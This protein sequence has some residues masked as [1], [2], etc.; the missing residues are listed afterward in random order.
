MIGPAGFMAGPKGVPTQREELLATAL[1][2]REQAKRLRTSAEY[3]DS[4]QARSRDENDARDCI[5]RAEQMEKEAAEP[6]G[7]DGPCQRPGCDLIA[8][9]PDCGPSLIDFRGPD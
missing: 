5:R 7:R 8:K 4:G 6:Y 2:L 9:C 1:R 3:A